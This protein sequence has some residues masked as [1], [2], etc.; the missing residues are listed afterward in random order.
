MKI[1]YFDCFAGISGDMILGALLDAGVA[2]QKLKAELTKLKLK[3]FKLKTKKVMRNEISATKVSVEINQRPQ[4]RNLKDILQ[5]INKSSLDNEVKLASSR[6]FDELAKVEAKIHGQKK[7]KVQFHEVGALDSIV[8]I[9]GC[10]IGFKILGIEAVYASRLHLGRGF[11]R[12]AHGTLPVPAPATVALLKGVPVYSQGLDAELVTP[13]GAAILKCCAKDFGPMPQMQV[14]R[15]GYGA[16]DKKLPIPNLLRLFLGET[17]M[18]G[19]YIEEEITLLETNID[20]M[21]PEVFT[22]AVEQLNKQGALDVYMSPVHMKKNRI[23]TKLTVLSKESKVETLVS[24]IFSET[25]TL[26]IRAQRL[27]RYKLARETVLIKTK[28]GAIKVKIARF[29]KKLKNIAP[30]YESCKKTALKRG[31]PF[32]DVYDEAKMASKK[33]FDKP[34]DL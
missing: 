13:T 14:T 9:V 16:G 20:D 33:T 30:E 32:K 15:I 34:R 7:E 18:V 31:I 28:F 24:T 29:G 3:G 27:K 12:C 1:A 22:Y 21:S 17:S 6:V 5:L 11:V 26:G 10:F 8:D 2:Q 19:G 23:G 4:R 25:T